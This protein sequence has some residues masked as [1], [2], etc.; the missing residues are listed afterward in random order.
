MATFNY[1]D[2][3][4]RPGKGEQ[5]KKAISLPSESAELVEPVK[6]AETENAVE[7]VSP[8]NGIPAQK[9]KII[10][11]KLCIKAGCSRSTIDMA[12]H[13]DQRWYCLRIIKTEQDQARNND[14][15]ALELPYTLFRRIPEAALVKNCPIY[16]V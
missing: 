3:L 4:K 8:A 13:P 10:A 15:S 1:R 16:G 9:E 11:S 2:R 7:E 5:V 6:Q 14:E 12:G